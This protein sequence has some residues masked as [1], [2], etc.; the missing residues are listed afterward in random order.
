MKILISL[1]KVSLL[2]ILMLFLS[3]Y[4]IAQEKIGTLKGI[5]KADH[6]NQ[7]V[8]NALVKVKNEKTKL[9]KEMRTDKNG[10]FEFKDLVSGKY[11]FTVSSP[12]FDKYRK[13][14]VEVVA[15]KTKILNIKMVSPKEVIVVELDEV[16]SEDNIS[17]DAPVVNYNKES[18]KIM[19]RKY[20]ANGIASPGYTSGGYVQEPVHNTESYNAISENGFKV[21]KVNPLSTFSIDVDAASYS[22]MR[23]F[24]LGGNKPAEGSVRVEEMINYF[25][26]DYEDPKDD[27]PFSITTEVGECPWSD[28]KLVHIGLQGKRINKKDLPASNLV[29]LLDVSGSMNSGNKLPLLKKSFKMLV[30]ELDERDRIAIVVYAGAAGVV[31]KS[32]A[33]NNNTAIL[34]SLEKLRAGGSTAGG[35]GIELAYKTAQ[36]NFIEGGN[37]RVILATDGDFNV[38]MSSDA[39]MQ[40]LIVKKRETGIFLTCLGFGMGNYKDS[41]LETLA[42]KGNG[43]Y[44]YIDNILEAKKVLVTEIGST[45]LTL[46]KDVKIQVEFNPSVI[47]SYRLVGYENRLLNEEDFNDDTKDAG[48]IGAGHSVTA[49]YEVVLKGEGDGSTTVDDLRYQNNETTKAAYGNEMLKVKFRYKAPDGDKSKLIE[50]ILENKV[51]DW[52]SLSKDYV[53]SAA[54]AEFGM[55]LTDSDH[56]GT[57]SFDHVLKLANE[58]KGRDKNGY[59][60]E[61][62]KLVDAAKTIYK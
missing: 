54:V 5:V 43:N 52:K 38:G 12:G 44:A 23:R 2:A 9:S 45:L 18:K 28:N 34:E 51:A 37:N 24:I 1:Q 31:L 3:G 59:R 11:Y 16:E 10:V 41:K 61:F 47:E 26:Y 53:F 21:S 40:S 58:G 55:L 25:Q 36:E 7:V 60:A 48:E 39:S 62:I 20:K 8:Y 15:G 32:T 56:K 22:N 14:H 57:A 30:N 19:G 13:S 46:A 49:L 27:V 35:A 4:S 33:A 17:R 50:R 29:F 42:D 6:S